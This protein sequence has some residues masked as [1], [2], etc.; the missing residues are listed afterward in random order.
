MNEPV[1]PNTGR[2][3]P[4]GLL[5][6]L[7]GLGGAIAVAVYV[8]RPEPV[9]VRVRAVEFGTVQAS[10]ANTRAGTLDACRRA[11][12]SPAVGGQVMRINTRAGDRVKTGQILL[13]L[14]NE[15]VLAQLDLAEREAEASQARAED[16]C[17]RAVDAAREATRLHRLHK[18]GL[19]SDER[20]DQAE[21]E[22]KG[23][24]AACRAARASLLVSNAR[25]AV[26]RATLN[27]TVIT[28]P[29]DGIVAELSPEV[30]EYVTPSPPGIATPPAVDVIDDSCLYVTAPIDEVDAAAIRPRMAA[31]I[32]LDALPGRRFAGSVRRV[33][34]YVVD[35]LKQARTVDVELDFDDPGEAAAL[36]TGYSV[37]VEIVLEERANVL[38]VPTEAVLEGNRV[39]LLDQRSGRLIERSITPGLSNWRYTEASDGL[40]KGD[41]LVISLDRDGVRAGAKAVRERP[42]G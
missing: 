26:R 7:A 22:A 28:A 19:A 29:F 9:A 17:V 36:L 3:W 35:L 25:I 6:M 1:A 24:D 8:T 37:D 12:I 33:A 13:E 38:R 34:P 30:G 11:R 16:A 27:K 41:L 32:T 39:L 4:R 31:A 15:D 18:R 23:R 40:E 21:T 5:L 14:W 20:R 2:R 10:V 42:S